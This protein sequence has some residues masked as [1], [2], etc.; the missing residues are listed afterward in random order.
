MNSQNSE[1]KIE[2]VLNWLK[3]TH[4][5]LATRERAIRVLNK[6]P[7]GSEDIVLAL[8]KVAIDKKSKRIK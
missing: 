6:L 2:I 4:P 8:Q 7:Q 1:E 5:E 3:K